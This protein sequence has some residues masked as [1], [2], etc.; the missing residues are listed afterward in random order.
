MTEEEKTIQ[1]FAEF[2]ALPLE[3]IIGAPLT[4][5]IQAQ[6]L[7]AEATKTYIE[8]FKNNTVRF[9]ISTTDDDGNVNASQVQV[10]LLSMIPVPH[11]RID[12]LNVS[13]R[14]D[15][16]HTERSSKTKEAGLSTIAEIGGNPWVN[17]SIT[18]SVSSKSGS[19][20]EMNRSGSLEINVQASEAP[21]PEGLAKILSLLSN[22]IAEPTQGKKP[23]K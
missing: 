10:P 20:A 22:S 7:A 2:Q 23:N 16:K 17:A 12:S 11:I 8:S 1:P 9:E 6:R 15:I 5:A 19:E 4:A 13:F 14:Y 3:Y 21:M 18:G